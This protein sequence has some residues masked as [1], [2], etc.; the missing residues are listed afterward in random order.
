M[1]LM[2]IRKERD[3]VTHPDIL[4]IEK[5]GSLYNEASSEMIGRC[6]Y[7]EGA[8]YEGTDAVESRDGMFCDMSCLCEYY[9]IHEI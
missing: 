4:T 9:E 1:V 2:V 3:E 6:L 8:V 5:F 7:C